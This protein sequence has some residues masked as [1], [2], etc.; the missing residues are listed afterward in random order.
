MKFCDVKTDL[1]ASPY[2]EILALSVYNPTEERLQNRIQA[3]RKDSRVLAFGLSK[4]DVPLGLLIL[5]EQDTGK[6][7]ILDFAVKKNRQREGLGS[8]MLDS[9]RNAFP[10]KEL[11]AE[12]DDE[13]V[14]FYRKYGFAI[15]PLGDIYQSGIKRYLCRISKDIPET[16]A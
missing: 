7:E 9:F 13:A 3:Y 6:Y 11:T 8:F 2:Q 1:S 5:R 12:T 4:Q 10:V 15:Q 14:E 16:S